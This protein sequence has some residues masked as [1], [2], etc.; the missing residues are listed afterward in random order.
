MEQSQLILY[1][2]KLALG[3]IVAFLAILLWSRT[4]DGAWMSL[5]AGAIVSYAGIVY[6]LLGDLGI[7]FKKDLYIGGLSLTQLIFTV[8]PPL[9]YIIAFVLML[10][11]TR[12]K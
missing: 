3:G 10:I 11:R 4:R 5:V 1:V 6:Q 12:S 8:I 7:F 9:F 2:I